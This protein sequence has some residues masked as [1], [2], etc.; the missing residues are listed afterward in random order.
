MV[1]T[2]IYVYSH[3]DTRAT[4]GKYTCIRDKMTDSRQCN[5]VNEI[6]FYREKEELKRLSNKLIFLI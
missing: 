6:D 5:S 2:L 1:Q 4:C 3:L